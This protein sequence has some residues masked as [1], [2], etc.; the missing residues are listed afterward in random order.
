MTPALIRKT[1]LV[2]AIAAGFGLA[3]CWTTYGVPPPPP[4][5]LPPPPPPPP[6]G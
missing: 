5:A 1:V 4:G 3:G 2:L 6:G